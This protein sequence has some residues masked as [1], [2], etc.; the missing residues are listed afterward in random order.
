MID[1][2]PILYDAAHP[3][4][5]KAEQLRQETSTAATEHEA[6]AEEFRLHPRSKKKKQLALHARERFT[7]LRDAHEAA[8]QEAATV[9]ETVQ[10]SWFPVLMTMHGDTPF[11]GKILHSCGVGCPTA[12]P[13]CT[14]LGSK[15]VPTEDGSPG[16]ENLK[17]TM[18]AGVSC[19]AQCQQPLPPNG[20]DP[21]LF[22]TQNE[23]TYATDDNKFDKDGAAS[24]LI[25]ILFTTIKGYFF[26]NKGAL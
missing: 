23:F 1:G 15:R 21:V 2:V 14:L 9:P 5:L 10:E 13:R 25:W 6:A 18:Y 24:I 11:M 19:P 7:K 26:S 16:V 8:V 3:L 20:V 4:H 12:C 22:T 17:S